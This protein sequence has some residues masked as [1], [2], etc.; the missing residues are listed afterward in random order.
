MSRR[1]ISGLL[2]L[3]TV[4]FAAGCGANDISIPEA[5]I[6][7]GGTSE[8][9]E[10]FARLGDGIPEGSRGTLP[11]YQWLRQIFESPQ[12]KHQIEK[13]KEFY[14][15]LDQLQEQLPLGRR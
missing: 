7:N 5:G 1:L 13:T 10:Q 15:V 8:V 9:S 11:E 6:L 14:T 2:L 12:G 4:A 3:L